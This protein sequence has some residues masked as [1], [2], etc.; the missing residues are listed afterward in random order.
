MSYRTRAAFLVGS[1]WQWHTWTHLHANKH[2][3]IYEKAAVLGATAQCFGNAD[4]SATRYA[5]F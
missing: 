3:A 4:H 5:S 2:A 1:K